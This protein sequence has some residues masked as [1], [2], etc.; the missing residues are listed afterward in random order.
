MTWTTWFAWHPCRT[1]GD[2][3]VWLRAVQRRWNPNINL[4]SIWMDDP[5][6]YEGGWE[7]RLPHRKVAA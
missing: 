6:E 7:Y 1:L 2:R 4:C 5:G 3:F